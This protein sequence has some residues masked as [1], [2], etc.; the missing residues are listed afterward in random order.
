MT[1]ADQVRLNKWQR[2]LRGSGEG[3]SVAAKPC[4]CGMES[5]RVEC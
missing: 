1:V 2:K 5:I 4:A 3:N